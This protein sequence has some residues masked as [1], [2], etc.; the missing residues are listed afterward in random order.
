MTITSEPNYCIIVWY[1]LKGDAESNGKGLEL[2]EIELNAQEAWGVMRCWA[3][4]IL[5]GCIVSW[6]GGGRGRGSGGN[7]TFFY[8][9]ELCS[10]ASVL[11]GPS[12]YK[13]V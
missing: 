3:V 6:T 9:K 4:V 7:I 11:V 13:G 2:G 1:G 12:G 8:W 5:K 10:A